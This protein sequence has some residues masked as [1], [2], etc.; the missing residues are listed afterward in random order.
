VPCPTCLC[1]WPMFESDP[2]FGGGPCRNNC[3]RKNH[4]VPRFRCPFAHRAWL[5]LEEL[6]LPYDHKL[7]DPENKPEDFKDLYASIVQNTDDSAKV[8]II[9]GEFT[10]SHLC[11]SRVLLHAGTCHP[12]R[13]F[14][15]E[16]WLWPRLV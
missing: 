16:H 7:V 5:A 13:K 6:G 4:Y 1:T 3:K 8:P 9:I 14:S 2:S 12:S 11:C 10:S 15:Q